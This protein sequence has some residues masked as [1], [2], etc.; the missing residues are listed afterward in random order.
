[1][2]QN[3]AIID[4]IRELLAPLGAVNARKMFGGYGVYH[5]SVMIGLVA[6]GTLFLKTDEQTRQQFAAAGCQPFVTE[7]KG[8]PIEMSYWSA[9]E[10]AMDSAA[11]MTPWARLAYAA[12]LRKANEKLAPKLP[13]TPKTGMG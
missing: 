11:A 13:K 8:K 2:F 10:D 4:Y 12:A 3:D 7:S 6:N 5:D 9:P 1:M